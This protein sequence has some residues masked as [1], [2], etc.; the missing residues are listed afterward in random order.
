MSYRLT[1]SYRGGGGL[2][3]SRETLPEILSRL[4]NIAALDVQ[5][6][7]IVHRITIERKD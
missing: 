7:V 4:A 1:V 5:G 6:S 2:S 3:T